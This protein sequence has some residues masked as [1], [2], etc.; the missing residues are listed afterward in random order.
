MF[1]V[2]H[3]LIV[4]V[5]RCDSDTIGCLLGN[6][7]V[8]KAAFF[9]SSFFQQTYLS[10]QKGGGGGRNLHS[11]KLCKTSFI[12]FWPVLRKRTKACRIAWVWKCWEKTSCTLALPYTFWSGLKGERE[13]KRRVF[14]LKTHFP[15]GSCGV[16][17]TSEF[18]SSWA[19]VTWGKIV[20]VVWLL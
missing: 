14:N 18:K 2:N 3:L 17:Q 16:I 9:H 4:Q 20:L 13:G 15:Q 7:S 11:R 19:V 1:S 8:S 6:Q 12:P 10:S 5:G